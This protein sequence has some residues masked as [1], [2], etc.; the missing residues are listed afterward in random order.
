M[1][2]DPRSRYDDDYLDLKFKV[3]DDY[4]VA[5]HREH[6]QVRAD[7][8]KVRSDMLAGFDA[9]RALHAA[10]EE[11]RESARKEAI[12]KAVEVRH[13]SRRDLYLALSTA[14]AILASATGLLSLLGVFGH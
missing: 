5:E 10:Q 6:E 12:D 13:S 7:I 2:A 11:K 3:L 8:N 14:A 4:R 1:A 9:I